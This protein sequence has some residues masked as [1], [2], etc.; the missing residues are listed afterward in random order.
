MIY[1]KSCFLNKN[2]AKQIS[3][4][5]E[6]EGTFSLISNIINLDFLVEIE[7]LS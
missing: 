3:L 2:T 6:S 7:V 5:A 4:G 1:L